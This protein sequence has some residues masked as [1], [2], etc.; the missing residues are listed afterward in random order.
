MKIA[1]VFYSFSGNTRNLARFIQE[2][3]SGHDT[4]LVDLKLAK[5]E[6]N[7]LAQCRDAAFK[8]RPEL[9]GSAFNPEKFDLIIF[10]SP[11]WAYTFTPALRSVLSKIDNLS[12]KKAA[13]I[14]T[15][16][17]GAGTKKALQELENMLKQ[18]GGN[19]VFT[20][21]VHGH[22]CTRAAYLNEQLRPLFD[23]CKA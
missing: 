19:V 8:K 9:A 17:S 11:V 21:V 7:F 5:E 20:G 18:K 16:G 23:I 13:A 6:R 14:L 4:T 10:A 15:C 1:I 22:K 12:N 2:S 3:F